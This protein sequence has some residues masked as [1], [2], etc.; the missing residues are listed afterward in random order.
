MEADRAFVEAL[1]TNLSASIS[2]IEKEAHINDPSFAWAVAQ[3]L[4]EFLKE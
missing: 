3:A 1:K 2:V 4:L